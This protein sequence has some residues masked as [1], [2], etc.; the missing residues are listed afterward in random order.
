MGRLGAVSY[1][2][3]DVVLVKQGKY[4]HLPFA[5]VGCEQDRV[6]IADGANYSAIKPKKKNVIHLQRT[7]FYLEDVAQYVAEGKLLDN[8]WLI[9]RLRGASST[10]EA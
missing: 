2:P 5:V 8:G 4:N 3:G 1:K 7:H 6:L 9:Q 10:K